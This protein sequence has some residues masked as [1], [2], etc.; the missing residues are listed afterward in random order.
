MKMG[1]VGTSAYDFLT[2]R[3]ERV[4]ELDSDP[5]KVER[6][7]HEGRRVLHADAEDPGFW[8]RL[9]T[10]GINAILLAMS[11]A[12]SKLIAASELRL[13]GFTGFIGATSKFAEE[14]KSIEAA[15]CDLSFNY[16]GEVGV[17]FA[18]HMWEAMNPQR[19]VD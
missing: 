7:R 17:G 16:Y 15:G 19:S 3:R 14:S 11:D 13:K 18:E 1:R 9:K 6:H 8:H 2:E 5:G 12:E 4:V 10:D